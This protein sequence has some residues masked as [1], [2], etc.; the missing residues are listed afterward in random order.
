MKFEN[1]KESGRESG[2]PYQRRTGAWQQV[3]AKKV[4]SNESMKSRTMKQE[5]LLEE[6]ESLGSTRSQFQ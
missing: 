1:K 5:K 2:V 4:T 3:V 6:N